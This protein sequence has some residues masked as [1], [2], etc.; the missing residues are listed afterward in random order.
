MFRQVF[1]LGDI[2]AASVDHPAPTVDARRFPFNGWDRLTVT[3]IFLTVG[4][5][6][7][8]WICAVTLVQIVAPPAI[9]AI[10]IVGFTLIPLHPPF[11]SWAVVA[12]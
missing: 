10:V 12:G 11:A 5:W 3:G 8:I 2:S 9:I 1:S 7:L 6:A 4:G